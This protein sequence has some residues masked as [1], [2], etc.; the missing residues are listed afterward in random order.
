MHDVIE[1]EI[2]RVATSFTSP[3]PDLSEIV[4]RGRR[5]VWVRR[6]TG[7]VSAC[8][9]AVATPY[10]WTA[11]GDAE[12]AEPRGDRAIQPAADYEWQSIPGAPIKGR[13]DALG[14]WTGEEYI[15]WGGQTPNGYRNFSDG[16]AYDP[17][18]GRWRELAPSTVEDE[19]LAREQASRSA[20]WT[21]T[22]VLLWGGAAGS[23]ARPDNGAAYNPATDSWRA[24][25]RS[26][27]WSLGRHSA[28]WTGTEMIV[29]GG[30]WGDEPTGA[31]AYNPRTDA[32]RTL[33]EAPIELRHSHAAAWTGTEMVI[34]GGRVDTGSH[35]N[36]GAAFDPATDSWRVLPESPLAPREQSVAGVIDGRVFLWGGTIDEAQSNET[37]VAAFVATDGAA[38]DPATDTWQAMPAVDLGVELPFVQGGAVGDHLLAVAGDFALFD[39]ARSEWAE[40][41][42]PSGFGGGFTV[43]TTDNSVFVWGGFAGS[44]LHNRGALLQ[45]D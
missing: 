32:W 8:V 11:F 19:R 40:L 20:V 18:T 44:D 2:E 34:W 33:P 21:G 29:F 42:P 38:Y 12:R 41:P 27:V 35:V 22:E 30:I 31:A 16:A 1:R 24:L 14:V 10:A 39:V 23:H 36:D 45:L 9:V 5:R 7:M 6:I 43:I 13:A 3:D 15:V 4:A 28:V 37:G 17:D 25:A 26:P